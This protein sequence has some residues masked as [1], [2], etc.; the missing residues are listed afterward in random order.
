MS[1]QRLSISSRRSQ[2]S[3]RSGP[4]SHGRGGAGNI[5]T[6]PTPLRFRTEL[7]RV[8]RNG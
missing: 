1:E 4:V 8:Y 7:T 6:S 2:D 3:H 5:S